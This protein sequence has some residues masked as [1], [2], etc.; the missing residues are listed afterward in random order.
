MLLCNH[1]QLRLLLDSIISVSDAWSV[2]EIG[3]LD[4]VNIA[5]DYGGVR[6][7]RFNKN[8]RDVCK[9]HMSLATTIIARH[10]GLNVQDLSIRVCMLKRKPLPLGSGNWISIKNYLNAWERLHE[11]IH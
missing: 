4:Q 7:F 5:F 1:Q 3:M 6:G 11:R 9:R 2:V 10:I 8:A